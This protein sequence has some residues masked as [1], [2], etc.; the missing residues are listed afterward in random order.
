MKRTNNQGLTK[1]LLEVFPKFRKN[2]TRSFLTQTGYFSS[3]NLSKTSFSANFRWPI[4]SQG[5]ILVAVILIRIARN[6]IVSSLIYSSL[7]DFARF[8]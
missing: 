1:I 3:R 5:K 8:A 2:K 6:L 7:R 4:Q